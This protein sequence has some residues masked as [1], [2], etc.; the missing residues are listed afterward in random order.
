MVDIK[1][2]R[3]RVAST[4]ILTSPEGHEFEA[5]WIGGEITT[6]K[7]VQRDGFPFVAG[8]YGKDLGSA[9][10]DFVFSIFFNGINCDLD[11]ELFKNAIREVGEWSVK[12]PVKGTK[13]LLLISSIEKV[14]PITS[15]G[16]VEFELSWFEPLDLT[17]ST[18]ELTSLV[19]GL[20]EQA[21]PVVA[22]A[23]DTSSLITSFGDAYSVLGS[24]AVARAVIYNVL[25]SLS[26][27]V[28][29]TSS[30]VAIAKDKWDLA[31][32]DY[33]TTY[34]AAEENPD[35]L[36]VSALSTALT[37]MMMSTTYGNEDS[38]VVMTNMENI[39][40]GLS[41][42]LP[43]GTFTGKAELNR[44]NTFQAMMEGAI[45]AACYGMAYGE[46][47]TRVEALDAATRLTEMFENT[48]TA[49][50]AV[51]ESFS[52]MRADRQYYAQTET[53]AVLLNLVTQTKKMLQS[54]VFDL[55]VE[56]VFT[57]ECDKTPIQICFEEFKED[58]EDYFDSIIKW[59]ELEGD[60]I[61]LLNAGR[62]MR[63]YIPTK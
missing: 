21:V 20:A 5:K 4:I 58:G 45:I 56:K 11:A 26:W 48:V 28:S 1:D 24:I 43:D 25:N 30:L 35:E 22:T 9:S 49:F 47:S 15:A 52:D 59:N 8:Q 37:E 16:I 38:N 33:Q 31:D 12:H 53:Y 51:A 42:S 32:S 61:L 46:R 19:A 7:R 29:I 60:D 27:M 62:E 13:T 57:L 2:S 55:A 17:E 14:Q 6:E 41:V 36:N 23:F 39:S 3:S 63:V 10:D 50:D 44:T 54:Q 34:T 18:L 40:D